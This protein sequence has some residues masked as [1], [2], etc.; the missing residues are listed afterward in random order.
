MTVLTN[1]FFVLAALLMLGVMVLVHE[2]GHFFSAR[3]TGIPVKEFGIGF[4]P[5]ITSWKSKKYDTIF[6]LRL[7]P[8][9]GYC[10]FYGEDDTTGK[11]ID[12]PRSLGNHGVFKR[13]LTIF[14]GPMMNFLLALVVAVGFYAFAGL[15]TYGHPVIAEVVEGGAAA[16]AGILAGDIVTSIN[17][18]DAAGL[19]ADGSDTRVRELIGAHQAGDVPMTFVITRGNESLTRD[20]APRYDDLEGRMMIGVLLDSP[21][22]YVPCSLLTAVRAGAEYCV[23]AGGAI[24]RGLGEMLTSKAGIEN[25]A[26]PVGVIS[27]ITEETRENGWLS[28]MSL[29]IMISVNLGLFNLLPIPGLDGSRLIFLLVE[30]VRRKPV[31]QRIEAYIHMGGYLVLIGLIIVLTYKDIVKLFS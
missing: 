28:Y 5:K 27:M 13:M 25:A 6:Q 16:E 24:L 8:A 29:L 21:V 11:K 12:D 10:M 30:A 1:A 23:M 19:S 22:V 4:G 14:M 15:Q 17:G 9:G 18:F 2:C 31:P 7:I 3:L 20:I 26:G